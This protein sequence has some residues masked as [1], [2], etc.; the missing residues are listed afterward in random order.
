MKKA[1][2]ILILTIVMSCSADKKN[3]TGLNPDDMTEEELYMHYGL[4]APS[5]VYE[6][7]HR[8]IRD[9][10]EFKEVCNEKT[11]SNFI[12]VDIGLQGGTVNYVKT[13]FSDYSSQLDTLIIKSF[14]GQKVNFSFIDRQN[15]HYDFRIDIQKF[16]AGKDFSP[17]PPKDSTLKAQPR[18]NEYLDK[19]KEF[20]IE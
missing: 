9:N 4:E 14:N 10:K 5:E 20:R 6:F 7:L 3:P 8:Q 19:M 11:V 13:R 2:I 17:T 1:T 18:L 12:A 15:G 16:C